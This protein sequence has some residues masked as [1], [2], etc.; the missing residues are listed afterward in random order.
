MYS[1]TF[2]IKKGVIKQNYSSINISEETIKAIKMCLKQKPNLFKHDI[3][4]N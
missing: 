1:I 4:L 2:E 3:L